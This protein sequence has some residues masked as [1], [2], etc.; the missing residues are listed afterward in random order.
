M[1]L[2]LV[3]VQMNLLENLMMKHLMNASSGYETMK[4]TLLLTRAVTHICGRSYPLYSIVK[5]LTMTIDRINQEKNDFFV[6]SLI[7]TAQ[8]EG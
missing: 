1:N 7:F 8:L 5:Q 6:C 2:W 3:V 4:I